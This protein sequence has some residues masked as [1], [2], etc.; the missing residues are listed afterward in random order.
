MQTYMN[1]TKIC[2]E[3]RNANK[4][5][6]VKVQN[7]L[8]GQSFQALLI[9]DNECK[10]NSEKGLSY[11]VLVSMGPVGAIAPTIFKSLGVPC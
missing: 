3:I 7:T 8:I 4:E 10:W 5:R 11:R 9:K 6:L 2:F 1:A